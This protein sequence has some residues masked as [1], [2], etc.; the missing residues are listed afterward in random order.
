MKKIFST[1]LMGA[2]FIASVGMFTS[3]KDYDDDINANAN[4]IAALKT[5]L[6]TLDAALK[7]AQDDIKA[8]AGNYATKADIKS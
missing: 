5:Q 7:K 8:A 2:F 4:D 6:A 1:L 3:C